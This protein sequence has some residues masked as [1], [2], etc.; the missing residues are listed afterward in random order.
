VIPAV[1]SNDLYVYYDKK[2]R[3]FPRSK[4]FISVFFKFLINNPKALMWAFDI[5]SKN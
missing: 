3:V 5:A 4:N 2:V 1:N